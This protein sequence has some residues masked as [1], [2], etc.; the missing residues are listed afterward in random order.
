VVCGYVA[1]EAQLVRERQAWLGDFRGRYILH[2]PYSLFVPGHPE[3]APSKLR[4]WIGDKPEE[5]IIWQGRVSP[6]EKKAAAA[7]FPEADFIELP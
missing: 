2:G 4:L 3:Q 5:C 6:E 1:H 7:L